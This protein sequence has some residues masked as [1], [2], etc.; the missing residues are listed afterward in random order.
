MKNLAKQGRGANSGGLSWI[1]SNADQTEPVAITGFYIN[2]IFQVRPDNKVY[3]STDGSSG[4]FG[5][6]GFDENFEALKA[7]AEPF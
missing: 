6:L 1:R 7:I 5:Y 4:Y 3:G 2:M